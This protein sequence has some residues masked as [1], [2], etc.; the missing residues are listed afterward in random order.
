MHKVAY[1]ALLLF[2]V[3]PHSTLLTLLNEQRIV[4]L[5]RRLGDRVVMMAKKNSPHTGLKVCGKYAEMMKD[6]STVR[7]VKSDEIL[8]STREMQ[9]EP[10]AGIP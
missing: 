10:G 2:C 1:P 7:R 6:S 8:A 3:T 9:N 5:R 4:V